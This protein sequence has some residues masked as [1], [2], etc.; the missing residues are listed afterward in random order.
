MKRTRRACL[1]DLA[2]ALTDQ[3]RYAEARK[4]YEDGLEIAKELD[5]LRGQGVTLGQL[6]TLAMRE[7]NLDEAAERYRA[8][9][10]LFQQ[11][12]EPADESRWHQLGR[13]FQEA[14][15]WDEAER[16]YREAARIRKS[17][18]SFRDK[19]VQRHLEPVGHRERDGRQAGSRGDVVSERRLR[20]FAQQMIKLALQGV[21]TTL[22]ISC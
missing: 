15:E 19:T 1:T 14:Q 17:W 16:H 10:A 6:G 11:L 4:A 5:D 2:D 20:V 9:L 22:P 13:V 18:A 7:G 21:S 3:G 12:G 8:A